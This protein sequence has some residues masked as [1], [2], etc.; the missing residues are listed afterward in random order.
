MENAMAGAVVAAIETIRPTPIATTHPT[1]TIPNNHGK[2]EDLP[3]F[4]NSDSPDQLC[5]S[6]FV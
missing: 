5:G 3:D 1:E 6:S 4:H 2:N